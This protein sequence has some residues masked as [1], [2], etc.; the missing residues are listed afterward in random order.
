M[1]ELEI[2]DGNNWV[3]RTFA[4]NDLTI[5]R[6]R[7]NPLALRGLGISR[8]HAR[9][10]RVNDKVYIQ[11][12]GSKNGTYVNQQKVQEAEIREGDII[13]I[14]PVNLRLKEQPRN[15]LLDNSTFVRDIGE[16][17]RSEK[18]LIDVFSEIANLLTVHHDLA[19]VC[20]KLLDTIGERIRFN[21]AIL[22]LWDAHEQ[23]LV[24]A[25]IKSDRD[26]GGSS[27]KQFSTTISEK[28]FRERVGIL[29]TN[30][31]M[32]PRFTGRESIMIQGIRS[33]ICVPM[34]DKENTIGVI[35]MDSLMKEAV[36]T[37][38]DLKLL[39]VLASFA[40]V[41][42]SQIRLA[43]KMQQEVKLRQWLSRYHSPAVVSR[44]ITEG[45]ME[46]ELKVDEADVSVMFCDIVGFTPLS[47]RLSPAEV[48]AL[49]NFF[50][51][52]MTDVIFRH[53]GTLDK[54]IGDAIMAVFGAPNR[55]VDHADAA[56]RC[57]IEIQQT[58][59]GL[60]RKLR[61][62][63]Q[64]AIRIGINSG[65]VVAGDIGS[66]K[67]MEYTVLGNTVNIASR[68]ES[69]ACR[70]GSIVIGEHTFELLKDKSQCRAVGERSV[71][72]V[73]HPI[74]VYEIDWRSDPA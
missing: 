23:C 2:L 27:E 45:T 66:E 41:G 63:R 58:L 54:F 4:E 34:W 21:R 71:K 9:L 6:S 51:S 59:E 74:T 8:K 24:P 7:E 46:L 37:S 36:Y 14:G 47:S 13:E 38:E 62:D 40:A 30:A 73:D 18:D 31:M 16:L 70:P 42:I 65:K 68:L 55:M 25:A 57:A 29:T 43:R 11:D 50:F 12:L 69:E 17:T 28:A 33:A 67:R 19:A 56:V 3:T 35:Y 20:E 64:L 49:L 39:S 48:A 10:Y 1:I 44:L 5:G 52:S 32:D 22:M 15:P 60:N 72:G 26:D 53:Q 61:E